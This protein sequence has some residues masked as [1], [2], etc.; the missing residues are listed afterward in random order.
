[1]NSDS[2][3]IFYGE[4]S[5]VINVDHEMM[6][7]QT[8]SRYLLIVVR[9][10]SSEPVF[11][12]ALIRYMENQSTYGTICDNDTLIIADSAELPR[13]SHYLDYPV[14]STVP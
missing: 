6:L 5:K 1:M 12:S 10:D 11:H 9:S 3:G 7:I 14:T 8:N 4:I 2:D 13:L